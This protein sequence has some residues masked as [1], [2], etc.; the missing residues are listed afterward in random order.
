MPE[1]VEQ[2]LNQLQEEVAR[3]YGQGRYEQALGVAR[4][5]CDLAHRELGKAR[6]TVGHEP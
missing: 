2:Q 1:S 6:C 5:S 4:Q 3:L